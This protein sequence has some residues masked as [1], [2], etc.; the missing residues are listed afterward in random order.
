MP[1][2]KSD[3]ERSE[4]ILQCKEKR[5]LADSWKEK[6]EGCKERMYAYENETEWKHRLVWIS[7]DGIE[8]FSLLFCTSVGML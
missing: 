7:K 3:G 1:L 5:R 6:Q 4:S 2:L 8:N